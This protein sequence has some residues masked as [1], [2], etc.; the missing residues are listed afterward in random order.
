MILRRHVNLYAAE[1]L[2]TADARAGLRTRVPIAV[3]PSTAGFDIFD[4]NL[5]KA[6]LPGKDASG[7]SW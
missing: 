3:Y 5:P 4:M 1:S 2:H 6:H 7:H